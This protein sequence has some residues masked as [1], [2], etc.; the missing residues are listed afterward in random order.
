MYKYPLQRHAVIVLLW[1]GVTRG[2]IE[3]NLMTTEND[4]DVVK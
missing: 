2:Y 4:S 1:K 3:H